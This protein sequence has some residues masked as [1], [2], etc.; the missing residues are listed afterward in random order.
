VAP[1]EEHVAFLRDPRT[2]DAG[3]IARGLRRS[4]GTLVVIGL[5]SDG[6][7]CERVVADNVDATSIYFSGNSRGL[8]FAN[9]VDD[10][11]VGKLKTADADGANV[12]MV[13]GSAKDDVVVGSTVFFGA[14]NEDRYL[15]APIAGGKT[16][17]LGTRSNLLGHQ[18][19]GRY[20]P[21]PRWP[22]PSTLSTHM[23]TR[24]A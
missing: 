8:V 11:G 20:R 7:A 18:P 23:P 21:R 24:P 3:C 9:D 17:S 6:S 15:A 2:F 12:R 22:A 4:A 5:Q 1:D 13:H 14:G 19:H 16:V 10:C